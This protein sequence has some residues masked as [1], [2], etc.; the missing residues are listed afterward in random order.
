MKRSLTKRR[1]GI[2]ILL[3]LVLQV[4]VLPVARCQSAEITQLL[5][6]I[7]KLAQLKNILSD[8]KK[9]Y[10][11]LTKGYNTVRDISHGNFSLHRTFLDGLLL[12]NPSIAKYRH[13]ADI[14]DD[15][16]TLIAEYKKALKF[17][18]S[19]GL[20]QPWEIDHF[21]DVYNTLFKASVNNLD[22]LT[23]IIT[24][25]QLRMSDDER[26]RGIDRIYQEM[27]GQLSFLR[28]FNNQNN[29]MLLQRIRSTEDVESLRTLH[30]LNP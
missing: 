14:I 12:V 27:E 20:C 8:M 19:S 9:G 3:L 23:M 15:E 24:A 7:E 30:G 4:G 13:V 16:V 2:R 29:V 21:T 25:Q 1:Y 11:I 5:L 22:E 26:L 10:E 17:F 18:K 28:A 6:D